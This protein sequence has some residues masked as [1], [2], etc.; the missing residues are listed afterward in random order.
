[1]GMLAG[2][3]AGAAL[4]TQLGLGSMT[5][6]K[7]ATCPSLAMTTLAGGGAGLMGS[8]LLPLGG[9]AL[10]AALGGIAG[11]TTGGVVSCQAAQNRDSPYYIKYEPLIHPDG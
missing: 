1:M 9:A 2:G 7:L 3:G 8:P 11:G 6:A 5:L 10:G 4:I